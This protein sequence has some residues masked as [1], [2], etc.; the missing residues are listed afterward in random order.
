PSPTPGTDPSFPAFYL[1]GQELL[2][3][4][5]RAFFATAACES[6]GAPTAANLCTSNLDCCGGSASPATAACQLDPPPLANPPTSHCVSTGGATCV[7]DGGACTSDAQCCNFSTSRCGS[8]V[9][10]PAPPIIEYQP[11]SYTSQY[12]SACPSQTRAVWRFFY[13]QAATP[14]G[15]SITFTAQTSSDGTN[16]GSAVDVGTAQPPPNVTPT[17]TS[18]PNTVDDQLQASGQVSQSQLQVTAQLNPDASHV[19]TPTLTNWQ[20]TYDCLPSE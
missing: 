13:W 9:C 10:G 20:V 17:W 12:V 16:W 18:G 11:A 19:E 8:G 2:A 3:G 4:N 7:A 14:D 5:S 1:P 6:P 15:T